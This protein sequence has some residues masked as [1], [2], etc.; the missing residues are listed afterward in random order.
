VEQSVLLNRLEN[1]FGVSGT[2]FMWVKSFLADRSPIVCFQS[3]VSVSVGCS[4]GVPQGSVL[5]PLLF[6]MYFAPLAKIV[7]GFSVAHYEH[8]DDTQA[9][10]SVAMQDT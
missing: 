7:T 5:G 2:A 8:A 6:I 3:A 10:V 4:R 9:Y 1:S